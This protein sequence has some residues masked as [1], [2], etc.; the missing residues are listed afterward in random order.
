[1]IEGDNSGVVEN[2]RFRAVDLGS[3]VLDSWVRLQ[4]SE[5]EFLVSEVRHFVSASGPRRQVC[6]EQILPD[7]AS[8]YHY[9]DPQQW[10]EV[11]G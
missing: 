10:V 9:L 3:S 2:R 4:D 7:G 5:E 1:M 6:I 8:R 11:I